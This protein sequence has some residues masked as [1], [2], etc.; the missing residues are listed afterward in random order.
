M[1]PE[2]LFFNT[3]RV[4]AKEAVPTTRVDE[5]TEVSSRLWEL[6][7]GKRDKA[8][9]SEVLLVVGG[10]VFGARIYCGQ[11]EAEDD[12]DVIG[13]KKGDIIKEVDGKAVA[14]LR[15]LSAL[16]EGADGEHILSI[17]RSGKCF[18]CKADGREVCRA[19][20]ASATDGAAGIGTVTYIN[21]EDMSFGGLGHGICN[22]S[23][24]LIQM[25]TGQVT[26]VILGG[27][28]RGEKGNPGELTGVLTNRAVG[29]IVSNTPTGVFGRLD[30]ARVDKSAAIPIAKRGE[31][32][33]GPASIVSTVRNGKK[34]TYS[35]EIYELNRDETGTKCFK[36][37]VTDPALLSLTGGIVRGMSGSPIIQNGKLVGA[38]THVM[39]ADPTEGYGIFIENMLNASVARNELPA[40]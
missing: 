30:E 37:R 10:D 38:V 12:I 27:A 21:P 18:T 14:N 25:G 9:D 39:V 3:G 16:L 36:L 29:S 17:E 32:K 1:L 28:K 7:F 26:G 19:I 40:A 6:L 23:G 4:H 2:I 15:E 33:V 35:V 8:E 11:I 31:V 24:E 34:M 22:K 13:I 20:V 5:K